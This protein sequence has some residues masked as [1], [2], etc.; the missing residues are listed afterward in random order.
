VTEA[1]RPR[2]ERL[3]WLWL[4]SPFFLPRDPVTGPGAYGNVIAIAPLVGALHGAVYALAY[5]EA[6]H[7]FPSG[8]ARAL[9]WALGILFNWI[10]IDG[11]SDAADALCRPRPREITLKIF[12]SATSGVAAICVVVAVEGLKLM[13]WSNVAPSRVIPAALAVP[14]IASWAAM[15][16]IFRSVPL[17]PD[18]ML[19]PYITGLGPVRFLAST[20]VAAAVSVRCLGV[21]RGCVALALA[22]IAAMIVRFLAKARLGAMSGDM[23]G[24]AQQAALTLGWLVA[25]AS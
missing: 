4:F 18:S 17:R 20:A 5:W 9:P 3:R 11:L 25:A 22:A 23:V 10:Q 15:V 14:V 7:F 19:S 1:K 8:V 13:C 16:S 6:A 21:V 24:M 2:P 12:K